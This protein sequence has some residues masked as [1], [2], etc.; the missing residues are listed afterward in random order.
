M[1]DFI[2]RPNV[3]VGYKARTPHLLLYT[4][5][6]NTPLPHTHTH[7]HWVDTAAAAIST[8]PPCPPTHP[9]ANTHQPCAPADRLQTAQGCTLQ[10]THTNTIHTGIVYNT[11]GSHTQ[12]SCHTQLDV[13]VC[14]YVHTRHHYP[15]TQPSTSS[16]RSA[17]TSALSPLNSGSTQTHSLSCTQAAGMQQSCPA[18]QPMHAGPWISHAAPSHTTP[19]QSCNTIGRTGMH[20]VF[21]PPAHHT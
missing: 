4:G 10:H 16:Q 21:E 19:Q 8:Q 11:P 13:Y 3:A 15:D 2:V 14:L 6:P 7:T 5:A 17:T 1:S 18:L 20:P 12:L 9:P